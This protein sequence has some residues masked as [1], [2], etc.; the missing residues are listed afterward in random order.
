MNEREENMCSVCSIVGIAILWLYIPVM[1]A[2]PHNRWIAM[3]TLLAGLGIVAYSIR[4]GIELIKK[5]GCGKS[6]FMIMIFL[7]SSV[8]SLM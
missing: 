8:I 2:D 7:L 4:C 3:R 6:I 1:A 5:S